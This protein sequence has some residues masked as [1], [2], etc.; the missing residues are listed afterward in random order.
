MAKDF[1]YSKKGKPIK[2]VGISSS[3]RS[4]GDCAAED[5][6]SL[7]LLKISLKEAEKAGAKTQLIDLRDFSIGVCKECYSTCPAQCRFSE[8]TY[9]CD[10]YKRT[11]PV[12]WTEKDGSKTLGEA[13]DLLDKK[14]FL[15]RLNDKHAFVA[16][17][18]MHVVY[19]ALLEADG[20]IFSTFTNYYSRPALLQSM[21]SR[22]CALD[23]GV[24][25]LWGDG[26][27]LKNSVNYANNPKSTYKQRMYGRFAAFINVSKEGD[28]V[29]PDLMK[30]CS[31]LGMKII[32]LSTSYN[33]QWYDDHTHRSDKGKTLKDPYTLHLAR[34][35][36][37]TIVKEAKKSDRSY[38]KESATV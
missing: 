21:F 3:K 6:T 27:N 26:K 2:I 16:A 19:K 23:G 18:D 4:L 28:S 12:I 35:I 5:P 36:G 24:E 10:C 33:V 37:K 7:E 15:K 14:E 22:M 9:Q 31:M 13:Y 1:L 30:A 11:E 25:E 20:V 17:D 8:V 38:G 32:P 29:T 34:H